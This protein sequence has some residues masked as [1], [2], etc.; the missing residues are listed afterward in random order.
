MVLLNF[1]HNLVYIYRD[2]DLSTFKGSR[3][4]NEKHFSLKTGRDGK[5][6]YLLFE[7]NVPPIG[8]VD[9]E[10]SQIAVLF[11]LTHRLLKGDMLSIIAE[12]SISINKFRVNVNLF[13]HAIERPQMLRLMKQSVNTQAPGF[14]WILL[15]F[16]EVREFRQ[17]VRYTLFRTL[18]GLFSFS[19]MLATL[20]APSIYQQQLQVDTTPVQAFDTP[21]TTAYVTL[22]DLEDESS[23]DLIPGISGSPEEEESDPDR[24]LENPQELEEA[25]PIIFNPPCPCTVM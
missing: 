11:K 18:K 9:F 15:T 1:G 24:D 21:A 17:T 14:A 25:D 4:N 19:I 16:D 20:A 5:T 8:E 12:K 22:L 10:S 23:I 13:E 3:L 7:K 2:G 6:E